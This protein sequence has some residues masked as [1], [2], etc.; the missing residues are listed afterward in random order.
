[1]DTKGDLDL[2]EHRSGTEIVHGFISGNKFEYK[3]IKCSIIDGLAIYE[4]DI[5]LGS[6]DEIKS[7]TSPRDI[8]AELGFANVD[9]DDL[10]SR[11]VAITGRRFRWPN[12][13]VPYS[14]DPNLANKERVTSAI[15]H[16][17]DNT[18]FRFVQPNTDSTLKHKN[19]ISFEDQGGCFS[20]VGMQGIG[21]QVISL[22]HNCTV[23]NAIHELGHALGLWHEQSREDRDK[24]VKVLWQN[25]EQDKWHNFEQ[26]IVD[27]DDIGEY[28]YGSIM[29]YSRTAFSK[30]GNDTIIPISDHEIGQRRGLSKED[31]IAIESVYANI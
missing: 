3:P 18:S 25:I 31:I 16:W 10:A 7:R 13:I 15:K 28:D 6:G 23:G 8:P 30:N 20:S 22:G 11:G 2:S 29:H 14:I 27:G 1:M 24:Y 21:K 4:G 12:K 17:E 9:D 5:L 19:Y 26:Q